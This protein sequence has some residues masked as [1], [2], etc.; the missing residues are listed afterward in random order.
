M[1]IGVVYLFGKV[2]IVNSDQF[3]SC[4]VIVRDIERKLFVLP[5]EKVGIG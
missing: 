3:V 4:C 5:R 1:L 2:R